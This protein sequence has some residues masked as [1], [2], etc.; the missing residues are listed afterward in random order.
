[1]FD[2]EQLLKLWVYGPRGY[3][4]P[5]RHKIEAALALFST[6][7]IIPD[8]YRNVFTYAQVF[9]IFRLI[10]A[11]PVLE[12]FCWKVTV[13]RLDFLATALADG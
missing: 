6:L 10:K 2:I 13:D 5:F 9:R 8:L 4:K 1:M 12:E 11:S 3:I 7:N